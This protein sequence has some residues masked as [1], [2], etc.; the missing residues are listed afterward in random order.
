MGR[1]ICIE[2]T[3]RHKSTIQL[4]TVIV[5]LSVI[6]VLNVSKAFAHCDTMGG[7]VITAAQRAL[8]T[9]NVNLI[10]IWV[11]Q[12][13]E[14]EVRQR[15]QETLGVRGLNND[16]RVVA[17][18]YFFETVVRLHRLGEGEPYTGIKPAGTDLGPV[19]PIADKALDSGSIEPLLR[20]FAPTLKLDIE[21]LFKDVRAKKSFAEDDVA[22]GRVYVKA[23]VNFLHHLEHVYSTSKK[24]NHSH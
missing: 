1:A 8:A 4:L 19:I 9:K 14:T 22:A 11:Q 23:Y 13:D 16:A 2:N 15:F 10:L 5:A 7:P 3:S 6:L 20:L 18:N 21:T 12:K 17:D 24:G